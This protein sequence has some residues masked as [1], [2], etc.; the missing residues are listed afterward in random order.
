MNQIN[1]EKINLIDLKYFPAINFVK[2]ILIILVF[3]GHIIPGGLEAEFP[4]YYIYSFHMPLFIGVS[5]FLISFDSLSL[6]IVKFFKKYW[7]RVIVPWI[8]AV[9]V[10]CVTKSALSLKEIITSFLYPFYHLWYVWAFVLYVLIFYSLWNIF[11]KYR[12]KW[13]YILGISLLISVVSKWDVLNCLAS[14][15]ISLKVWDYIQHY[16]RLY[17]FLFFA[18]GAFV[19]YVYNKGLFS[20]LSEKIVEILRVMLCIFLV[21]T[22]VLFY[23]KFENLAHMLFFVMNSVFLIILLYDCIKFNF[24]RSC[25]FEFL[26]KYTLP[27]Y[28]YH[29]LCKQFAFCYF[30]QNLLIYYLMSILSFIILCLLI[31]RCRNNKLI[32]RFFYGKILS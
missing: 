30:R 3:L 9:M 1:V 32:N 25:I 6:N 28:L 13:V 4:R 19:R 11:K 29:V 23:I 26:G 21:I 10:F 17:N 24:P 14:H 8:I 20:K 27:I 22:I 18:L 5:G 16:F 15:E 7:N 12:F 31:Y 2:G